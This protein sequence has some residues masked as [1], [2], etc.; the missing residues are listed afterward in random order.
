MWMGWNIQLLRS[1]GSVGHLPSRVGDIL[2]TVAVVIVQGGFGPHCT[3]PSFLLPLPTPWSE[4]SECSHH[5]T[6]V[7]L[8][9]WG[10]DVVLLTQRRKQTAP[11]L[12]VL[13]PLPSIPILAPWW[14]WANN[15][16]RRK[17]GAPVSN[18]ILPSQGWAL[19]GGAQ[20]VLPSPV[21]SRHGFSQ[22]RGLARGWWREDALT[23]RS[24]ERM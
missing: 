2:F 5:F 3:P 23:E 8:P 20:S 19:T 6:L 14:K 9:G 4:G 1:V 7:Q 24:I 12:C 10:T 13:P 22:L 21:Y 16:G 18:A 17:D 11:L 15:V